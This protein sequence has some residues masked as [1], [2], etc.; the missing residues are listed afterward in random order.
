MKKL[1]SKEL[2]LSKME[3]EIKNYAKL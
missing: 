2:E 3:D 1:K